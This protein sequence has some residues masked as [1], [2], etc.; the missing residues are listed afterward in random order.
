MACEYCTEP[1]AM[2]QPCSELLCHHKVHT[3]CML[4]QAVTEDIVNLR[5][6]NC[7]DWLTPRQLVDEAEAVHG[8]EGQREVIRYFWEHEPQFK[9]GLE[10]IREARTAYARTEATLRKKMKEMAASLMTEV[11]PLVAQIREKVRA[12]KAAFKVLPETKEAAKGYKSYFNKGQTFRRR[13]G[14]STW[15]VRAALQD[16]AAARTLLSVSTHMTRYH[17][18]YLLRNFNVRIV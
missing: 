12:A 8:Q 4:R 17:I 13:W 16:I 18:P 3:E 11:D 6:P 15:T 7:R 2:D 9:A 1:I 10:G 14:V 5:C